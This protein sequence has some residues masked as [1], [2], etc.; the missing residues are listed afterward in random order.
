MALQYSLGVIKVAE[1]NAIGRLLCWVALG[2]T[3]IVTPWA[4]Y[5]P[6]N[7]PKLVVI[8]TGGF[9]CLAFVVTQIK[10]LM[11]REFRAPL[12]IAAAFIVDLIL[13]LILS[14]TNFNQ[15]F[16]GT[17]GRATG[18]VA[19]V[20]LT[21]LLLA[22]VI[23]ATG[24]VLERFSWTLVLAGFLSIIYG[25]IQLAGLDPVS[26]IN[27]YS[28]VIGFFGNPDFQS[29]F[30]AFSS[31]MVF[32]M[33]LK[34]STTVIAKI[35]GAMYLL[36]GMF[37]IFKTGAQQG[38]LVLVAGITIVFLTYVK[39]SKAKNLIPPLLVLTAVS[40]FAIVI[41]IFNKG[42]LHLLHKASVIYRGDYWR[43]GWKMTIQ[44]PLFG[45]GLDS[46]G[47]WYR[48][49]RTVAATLRRGP[50][51]TSNAA[52]NVLIDFSSNGGFPLVIIYLVVLVIA[53]KAALV[54]IRR[55]TTFDPIFTGLLAV[56]V[57][58][59]L[60][61]VISL[62]QLGLAVWG[63]IISGLLIGWEITARSSHDVIPNQKK[64]NKS[65]SLDSLLKVSPSTSLSF[66]V[67]LLIGLLISVGP[68]IASSKFKSALQAQDP[69][70]IAGAVNIFPQEA[71]RSIQIAYLF[72][73]NK[74]DS[75]ALPII[76]KVVRKYPDEYPAW[77]VM[78]ML[79]TAS[80]QQLAQAKAQMKRLDP[81]NPELK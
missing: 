13:V 48:R 67:G 69:A 81:H 50:D 7:L 43:A 75:K 44:H 80:A 37:V 17:N 66:F 68:L 27:S 34:K 14:G 31:V 10:K 42:P 46:Y 33:L 73:Q 29:S 20:A 64:S 41:G 18:F 4:S 38:F 21:G 1:Q 65:R 19:Y 76:E 57:A 40:V 63:W 52:H 9:T 78:S 39:F 58:F 16:F 30:V 74:M 60:Q 35:S 22:G 23:S 24:S 49:A 79:T 32:S 3:L 62:N 47:D 61:S 45:I 12:L 6:I 11:G 28:P 36:A 53:I 25:L 54:V 56:W 70:L 71:A 51:I 72:Q 2:A 26:W 5:D 8:S 59:Q 77:K 55:S 15:E